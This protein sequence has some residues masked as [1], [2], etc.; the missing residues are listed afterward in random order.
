MK[1]TFLQAI[2]GLSLIA[3]SSAFVVSCSSDDN[4]APINPG[5]TIDPANFKGDITTNVTLDPSKTYTMTGKVAVKAG[6]SLT[7]PAGTKINVT[8]GELNADGTVKSVSYLIV[9]RGAK[10]YMNGTS[11]K[12]IVFEGTVHK[13]GHWG[14][15][16]L[17]GNAPSN[18]SA[19]GTSTS[20]LGELTYG[21]TDKTDNSGSLTYVVIKD[22]GFKYNPEKEFNGLSLFGVGSGTKV[23]NIYVANGGDDGVEMF[24]GNV[25]LSNIVVIGVGDDSFDWTEG[26]S[27]T[28]TNIYAARDKQYKDAA[29]PGN[30]GIEADTQDTDP[31]TTNGANGGISNPT[32]KKATFIG[33]L[34]GAESQGMK[35]RAGTNGKFDDIVLANFSTGLD[36]ET[37][38]TFNWFKSASNITNIRFVNVG[39]EWKA[40]ATTAM[41]NPDLS[42]VFTKN[43]AALGAGNGTALPEWA[44]NW[45]GLTSYDVADAGN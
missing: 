8:A 3:S 6:A 14:G 40:K 42:T 5:Q 45:T 15:I 16:V 27:G 32:I 11:A 21:G 7:I 38:R 31:N 4:P 1:K 33:N 34:K 2:L 35:L 10:I 30:R 20:E 37:D 26:W 19:A 41:P 44:K 25:N 23:E 39:T 17:L 36:F 28:A 43:N 29:E 18:R 12:P 22:S 9:E 24:G 13:Q